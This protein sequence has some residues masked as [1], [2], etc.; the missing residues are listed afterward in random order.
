MDAVGTVLTAAHHEQCQRPP[1]ERRS[2]PCARTV[3]DAERVTHRGSRRCWVARAALPSPSVARRTPATQASAVGTAAA[4]GGASAAREWPPAAAARLRTRV[5]APPPA[6]AATQESPRQVC[7]PG[8]S[9]G[10]WFPIRTLERHTDNRF[11]S[12]ELQADFQ[13]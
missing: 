3:S 13:N 12:L 5:A 6:A 11:E 1:T 2:A 8:A 7:P 9:D 10:N 4:T